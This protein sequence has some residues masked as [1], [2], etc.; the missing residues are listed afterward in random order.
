MHCFY[1]LALSEEMLF[2]SLLIVE[3]LYLVHNNEFYIC[4]FSLQLIFTEHSCLELVFCYIGK[5]LVEEDN[6]MMNV[7]HNNAESFGMISYKF[8]NKKIK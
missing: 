5:G 2:D 3:F 8:V 6:L 4:I 7:F 1:S